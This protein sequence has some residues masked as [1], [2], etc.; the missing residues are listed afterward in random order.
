MYG[1]LPSDVK[2]RATTYDM[3]VTEAVLS[4]EKEQYDRAQGKLATPNLSQEQMKAMINN[5]KKS[6][7]P[8]ER[9]K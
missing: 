4:W 3:M 6:K 1:V 8:K 9:N 7:P 5:V 2:L